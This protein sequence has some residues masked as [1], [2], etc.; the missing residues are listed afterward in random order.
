MNTFDRVKQVLVDRLDGISEEEDVTEDAS[1]ENVLMVDSLDRINICMGLEDEFIID[2][3]DT[4]ME[5]VKTVG[6]IVKLVD[7]KRDA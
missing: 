4:D 5:N 3:Y 6:D 2:I 1:L 7:E